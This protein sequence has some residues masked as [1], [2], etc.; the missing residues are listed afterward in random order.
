MFSVG[1]DNGVIYANPYTGEVLGDGQK[2]V[3][4]FF[5]FMTSWHR[6]LALEGMARPV[7]NFIT[8]T[9]ALL[10]FVM[11]VTGLILW[12]PKQWSGDRVRQGA[13]LNLKLRGKA[14]DWNWHNVV[15][16]WCSPLLFLVTFTAICM[17]QNWASDMLFTLTGSPL[18]NLKRDGG[19][20]FNPNGPANIDISGI[21]PLWAQA[22]KQVPGWKSISL[23]FA[24]NSGLPASFQIDTGDGSRPDTMAQLALE[25][26]DGEIDRWQPYAS[27][28]AGQKLRSWL[29][30]IH[31]GEAGGLIGES[32]AVLAALGTIMLV[33]SGYSMAYSRLSSYS[34]S[35]KR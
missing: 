14:R 19:R 2:T 17:S 8:S 6:W 28:N 7:G 29:K 11:L 34:G 9:V 3:R 22:E 25:R 10:Y 32:L 31:T 21:N 30:P 4:G 26:A 23:R 33:W 20:N 5:Q 24:G 27:E 13:M 35:K 1:R 15:G 12:L 18:P 16:L